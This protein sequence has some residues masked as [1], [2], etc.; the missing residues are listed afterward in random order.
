MA[1]LTADKELTFRG[2]PSITH[3]KA[4]VDVLYKGAFIMIDT[5]GYAVAGADTASCKYVGVCVEQCDNSAGSAGDVEVKVE[6]GALGREV[7][8]AVT[9]VD[10]ADVGSI[11]YISDD[12]TLTDKGT[13]SNDVAAGVMVEY[14]SAS[15]AWV[16]VEPGVNVVS[17]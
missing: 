5:N 12:Q 8:C 6:T 1:A 2:E 17:S 10:Q 3:F 16:K 4:G 9:S 13:A 7:K 14:V 11:L 15:V